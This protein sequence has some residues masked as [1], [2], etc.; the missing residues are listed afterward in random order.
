LIAGAFFDA[1]ALRIT[2]A[3]GHEEHVARFPRLLRERIGKTQLDERLA[4]HPDARRLAIDRV[5]RSTGK[6][7]FTRWTSRAGRRAFE[8]SM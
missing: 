3:V 1:V 2:R 7:T 6:S 5:S 8:L 4:R